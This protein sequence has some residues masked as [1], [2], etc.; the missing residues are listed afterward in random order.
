MSPSKPALSKRVVDVVRS[1]PDSGVRLLL[2]FF[3]V[4]DVSSFEIA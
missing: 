1:L 2:S 4:C 3:R